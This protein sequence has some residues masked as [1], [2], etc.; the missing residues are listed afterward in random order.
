MDARV[1]D[2]HSHS[3]YSDGS[4]EPAALVR[5]AHAAGLNALAL[6]DHDTVAGLAEA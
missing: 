6:T 1:A 3:C 4:D 2:L 5:L